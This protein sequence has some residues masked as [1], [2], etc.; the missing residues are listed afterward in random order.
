[1]PRAIAARKSATKRIAY[2]SGK[3]ARADDAMHEALSLLA[4]NDSASMARVHAPSLAEHVRGK[5]TW[6]AVGE[7]V[8]MTIGA[9]L[10]ARGELSDAVDD[11]RELH[12]R[13]QQRDAARNA[14]VTA[15]LRDKIMLVYAVA[16]TLD[17][18]LRV[19]A[20]DLVASSQNFL[21]LRRAKRGFA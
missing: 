6:A 2:R 16:V 9:R 19:A 5:F 18:V 15:A 8:A 14:R 3:R 21:R 4:N 20:G 13:L 10:I 7:W 1:M 17:E 12:V 11:A